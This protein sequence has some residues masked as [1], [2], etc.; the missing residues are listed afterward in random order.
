MVPLS[1]HLIHDEVKATASAQRYPTP[2]TSCFKAGAAGSAVTLQVEWVP[3][4]TK[5]SSLWFCR[6]NQQLAQC[7][8]GACNEY[9]CPL[10][11]AGASS[12]PQLHFQ[13]KALLN[14]LDHMK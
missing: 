8:H 4:N 12:A 1:S 3:P 7:R 10:K 14:S 5:P 11:P 13:K 9:G 6:S 2:Y